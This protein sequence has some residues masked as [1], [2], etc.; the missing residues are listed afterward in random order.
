MPVICSR[1]TRLTTSMR[2]CIGRNCGTM[3]LTIVPTASTRT[4]TL[5]SEQPGQ[6]DVLAQ[7]HDDAAD[8]HDRRA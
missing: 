5:T 7:R 2:S 1:S 6:S 8:T 4:G 3:R